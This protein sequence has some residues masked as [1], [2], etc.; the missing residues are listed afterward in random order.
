MNHRYHRYM[1]RSVWLLLILWQP[2]W[3][4]WQVPERWLL[5][6][7]LGLLLLLP[8]AGIWLLRPLAIIVA[9]LLAIGMLVIASM[10]LVAT[11]LRSPG[12]IGQ[13]LIS[14]AYLLIVMGHGW[15]LKQQH[16]AGA[17]AHE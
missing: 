11:G 12:A 9:S 8:L 6:V 5:G 1:L 15:R 2:I 4:G 17:A 16:Q 7:I 14:S 13:T 10:E 3:H